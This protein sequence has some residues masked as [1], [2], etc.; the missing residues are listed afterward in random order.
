M[1][2]RFP[3]PSLTNTLKYN[4]MTITTISESHVEVEI[5]LLKNDERCFSIFD[6]LNKKV[7]IIKG[8]DEM[9]RAKVCRMTNHSPSLIEYL[10]VGDTLSSKDSIYIVTRVS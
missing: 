4:S 5:G 2:V 3:L 6:P 8:Y 10:S 9:V 1:R 7:S